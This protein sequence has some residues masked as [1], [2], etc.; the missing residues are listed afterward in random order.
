[1]I[2]N[3]IFVIICLLLSIV[4]NKSLAAGKDFK[5]VKEVAKELAPHADDIEHYAWWVYTYSKKY[6]LD[7]YLLLAIIK[8]ESNFNQR[9]ISSTGDYSLAQINY[10]VWKK[11]LKRKGIKLNFYKLK[12][13][14]A[15]AL[16]TMGY[17]LKTLK[18]KYGSE[19]PQWY[20]RYHSNT[21]KY[22]NNYYNKVNQA[23]ISIK[24]I[25][26]DSLIANK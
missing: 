10:K 21:Y 14:Y 3:L 9:A 17:I 19:D 22:K 23:L 8:V 11:E 18:D 4:P 1:M 12:T 5:Q 13:N 24:S 25:Q 26:K 16:E 7:P 15:Y 2:K 20:A 6:K